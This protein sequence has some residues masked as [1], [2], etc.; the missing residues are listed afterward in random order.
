[1]ICLSAISTG[2]YAQVTQSVQV[3]SIAAIPNINHRGATSIELK[4]ALT[5][6][7]S[8][9]EKLKA[10][11]SSDCH[12]AVEVRFETDSGPVAA[13]EGYEQY[14][15]SGAVV[16]FE[17]EVYVY[18][19]HYYPGQEL[20]VPVAALRLDTGYHRVKVAI[21]VY[22]RAH[23]LIKTDA[24]DV[25]MNLRMPTVQR[26]KVMIRDISVETL[27]P[28]GEPWDYYW[29]NSRKALPDVFWEIYYGGHPIH[30]SET[31]WDTYEWEDES[32]STDY[33][34]CAAKGDVFNITVMDRDVLTPNDFIGSTAID[35]KQPQCC[36]GKLQVR[37]FN[38][39]IKMAYG[40]S[41]DMN[42]SLQYTPAEDAIVNP[43]KKTPIDT[44]GHQRK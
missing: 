5:F 33:V 10:K 31:R 43:H 23:Q 12:Y 42:A 27:D 35:T 39:V 14:A 22:D 25:Y 3:S 26:Y 41:T 29:F 36:T 17:D 24:P 30:L 11:D 37:K 13:A 19:G 2:A 9:E 38:S 1:M 44:T 18:S 34:F 16:T 4:Y 28:K 40:I 21:R 6:K 15:D 8:R 20:Y 7:Y 32:G